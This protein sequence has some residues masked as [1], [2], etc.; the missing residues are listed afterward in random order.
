MNWTRLNRL[1]GWLVVVLLTLAVTPATAAPSAGL[2]LEGVLRTSGGAVAPDGK[3]DLTFSL[4]SNK[5]DTKAKFVFKETGVSVAG[6]VFEV[7]LG[8]GGELAGG[9]FLAANV[10]WVGVAVGIDK[11]L[12]RLAMH[13]TPYA[14]GAAVATDLSCT[15]CVGKDDIDPSLLKQINDDIAAN[16]K[17]IKTNTKASS[18]NAANLSKVK[19]AGESNAKAIQANSTAIGVN[20]QTLSDYGQDIT[21]NKAAIGQNSK[22]IQGHGKSIDVNK[23]NIKTLTGGISDNKSNIATN[24]GKLV[25]VTSGVANNAK[26]IS[27]NADKIAGNTKNVGANTSA[28]GGNTKAIDANKAAISKKAD[29]SK[30]AKVALTGSHAD[31]LA[32]PTMVEVGKTCPAGQVMKGIAKDGKIICGPVGGPSI[33]SGLVAFFPS[34]C[35]TGWTEYAAARGRVIVASYGTSDLQKTRGT[36]LQT[37]G[38]RSITQVPAHTHNVNPPATSSTSAGLHTHSVD[39]PEVSTTPSGG[40]SHS[41]NPPPTSTNSSGSHSHTVDPPNTGTSSSGNHNHAFATANHDVDTAESQGFPAGNNHLAFRTTDRHQRNEKP[42][43]GN[44]GIHYAGNHSHSVNIGAFSSASSGNHAHTFDI[45]S[46]N[47]STIGNHSHTMNIS[48]FNSAVSGTHKHTTDISS[49]KSDS[50]GAKSVDVTMPYIQLIACR[51]N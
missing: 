10:G 15:G 44:Q 39:P 24:A 38:G 23:G 28:I 40:H 30:L 41:V 11:E 48:A 19:A 6:G 18:D 4:Y 9:K 43:G 22:V 35:P 45:G 7:V 42:G 26:D 50:T 2:Q 51:K 34:K 17:D 36:S 21:A 37:L 25:T 32:K 46:F 49:F 3:Y 14:Y 1:S 31:L 13:R 5:Q 27:G 16:T 8:A 47:S 12:P 29:A 20:K 33:P